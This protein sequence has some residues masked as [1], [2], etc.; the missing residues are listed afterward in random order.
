MSNKLL[1]LMP[2]YNF[3]LVLVHLFVISFSFIK[4]IIAIYT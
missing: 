1:L 4:T 3:M 2:H